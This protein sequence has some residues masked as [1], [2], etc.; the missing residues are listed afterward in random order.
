MAHHLQRRVGEGVCVGGGGDAG[1]RARARARGVITGLL[2]LL[3]RGQ[4]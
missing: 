3:E 1:A 2:S 4:T